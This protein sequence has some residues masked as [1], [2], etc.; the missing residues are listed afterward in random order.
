MLGVRGVV[1]IGH[2]RATPD[3]IRAAVLLAEKVAASALIPT[4]R[5]AFEPSG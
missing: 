5:A 2:G 3:D 1:V 4:L